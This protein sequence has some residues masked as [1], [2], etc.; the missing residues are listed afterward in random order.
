MGSFLS[1]GHEK[2][3]AQEA[4][5]KGRGKSL[6]GRSLCS[7]LGT[8]NRIRW[9]RRLLRV[10]FNDFLRGQILFLEDGEEGRFPF[11]IAPWSK[12]LAVRVIVSVVVCGEVEQ[13]TIAL[14]DLLQEYREKQQWKL[15]NERRFIGLVALDSV[16]KGHFVCWMVGWLVGWMVGWIDG[17]WRDLCWFFLFLFLSGSSINYCSVDFSCVLKNTLRAFAFVCCDVLRTV[18]Y[19]KRVRWHEWFVTGRLRRLVKLLGRSRAVQM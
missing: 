6:I 15:P 5:P 3:G 8:K 9:K 18:L 12:A 1:G 19:R 14:D 7:V 16:V 2:V 4:L 10:F 13:T 11:R 17:L